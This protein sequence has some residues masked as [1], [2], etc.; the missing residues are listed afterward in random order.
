MSLDPRHMLG[1]PD[2][3]GKLEDAAAPF[4]Y[5]RDLQQVALS[6][7]N[8]LIDTAAEIPGADETHD[9]GCIAHDAISEQ[10]N[11]IPTSAGELEAITTKVAT[12]TD[13]D[14]HPG[15]TGVRERILKPSPDA[16]CDGSLALLSHIDPGGEGNLG[17][18]VHPEA[19][20]RGDSSPGNV[21]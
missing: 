6:K 1:E 3:H 15:F 4:E 14:I 2:P 13:R 5:M 9:Q 19:E 10:S 21:G 12:S 20:E 11:L 17:T 18:D 16:C 7:I 8:R